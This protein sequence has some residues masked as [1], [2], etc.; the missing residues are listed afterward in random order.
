[1]GGSDVI[2]PNIRFLYVNVIELAVVDVIR[3]VLVTLVPV[4]ADNLNIPT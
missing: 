4:S 1:M 2:V 3:L